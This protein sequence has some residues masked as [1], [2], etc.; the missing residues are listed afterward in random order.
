[1]STAIDRVT[2]SD[3]VSAFLKGITV[4]RAKADRLSGGLGAQYLSDETLK[5]YPVPRME[6]RQAE[7]SMKFAVLET[8][9]KTIDEQ[10]VIEE[11]II[12]VAPALASALLSLPAKANANTKDE[13]RKSVAELLGDAAGALQE[14]VT[15]A[16]RDGVAVVASKRDALMESATRYAR[17]ELTAQISTL[18]DEIVDSHEV[19]LWTADK[20]L[21]RALG[22]C[23]T[24]W[25]EETRD[26]AQRAVEFALAEFFDLQIAV[27]RDQ[28]VNLPEHM[29]SELKMTFDVDNYVWTST[30]LGSGEVVKKLT[31][32]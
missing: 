13:D 5:S 15:T 8:A 28:L 12:A 29:I 14:A 18:L 9:D 6:I 10:L 32:L 7:V 25:A 24:K 22:D 2:I 17:R 11:T 26:A 16:I 3:L 31:R 19:P 1:M 23:V 4:A 20:N 27:K 30:K 21:A